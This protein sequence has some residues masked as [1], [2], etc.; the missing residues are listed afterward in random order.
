MGKFAHPALA[1]LS[2]AAYAYVAYQ[3]QGTLRQREAELYG[4]CIVANLAIWPWTLLVTWPTNEKLFKKYEESKALEGS[5]KESVVE[6]GLPKGES[7][8][9]L[10]DRW[11]M[12]NVIR[13]CMP[14]VAAVLGTYIS[15][16]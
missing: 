10:I 13:G 8:K 12:L 7:S 15:L 6:A 11:G 16:A 1:L 4:V 14:L 5:G 9:E 3:W 2:S